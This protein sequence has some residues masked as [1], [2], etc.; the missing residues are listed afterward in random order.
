MGVGRG[1]G[2]DFGGSSVG[3]NARHGV[4]GTVASCARDDGL[5]SDGLGDGSDAG[6]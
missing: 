4:V 2:T 3:R 6:A 5:D 1:R